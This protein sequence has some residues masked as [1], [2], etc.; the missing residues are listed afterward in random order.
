MIWQMMLYSLVFVYNVY[1]V[2]LCMFQEEFISNI[3]ENMGVDEYF[4]DMKI[5]F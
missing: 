2:V 3:L 4:D 1:F 5:F